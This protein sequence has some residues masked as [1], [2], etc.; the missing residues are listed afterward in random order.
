[1]IDPKLL[2]QHPATRR[3]E[4]LLRE[5][6]VAAP[7][8]VTPLAALVLETVREESEL[9]EFAY[10]VLVHSPV[11][12]ARFLVGDQERLLAEEGSLG[13]WPALADQLSELL[14]DLATWDQ[15]GKVLTENLLAS[16]AIVYPGS[17]R[18]SG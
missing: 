4:Q 18:L 11:K 13:E 5:R 6:R 17:A 12:A 15:A 8:G 3:A 1:M 9:A 7:P 16:R 10:A 2:Q 14:P